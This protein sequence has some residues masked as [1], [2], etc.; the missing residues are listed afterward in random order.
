MEN[1]SE[2]TDTESD[3]SDYM[4]ENESVISDSESDVEVNEFSLQNISNISTTSTGESCIKRI[5]QKL[6]EKNNEHNWRNESLDSFVQK[7][8]SS[9][10]GINKVFN[11]ELHVINDEIEREFGKNIF[12]RNDKK[13]VHVN[14]LFVQLRKMPQLLKFETSDEEN[15]EYY[16][17][18]TLFETYE[19]FLLRKKSIQKN[20]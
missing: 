7:Y 5:L 16:Q 12:H 1:L 17:P 18:K 9:K 13:L 11:Y 20:T 3:D 14:K 8:L 4:P 10:K 2:I 19:E 6:K 15:I